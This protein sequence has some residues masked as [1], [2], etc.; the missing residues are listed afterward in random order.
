M[1]KYNKLNFCNI[2]M[3]WMRS[4]GAGGGSGSVVQKIQRCLYGSVYADI[5]LGESL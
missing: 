4:A 5:S 3:A 1:D 2:V